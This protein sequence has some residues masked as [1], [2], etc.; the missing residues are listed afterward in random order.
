MMEILVGVSCSGKSTYA[1]KQNKIIVSADALRIALY[2]EYRMGNKEE[3]DIIFETL[4]HIVRLSKGNVVI[5]NTTLKM[6]YLEK[7][8]NLANELNVEYKITVFRLLDKI[9]LIKRNQKRFLETGK[10]IPLN[11]LEYQINNYNLLLEELKQNNIQYDL[12]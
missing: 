6:T 7:Y 2:G 12:F 4:N 10:L 8:I 3:E 9:E 11:L 1:Q 5:D